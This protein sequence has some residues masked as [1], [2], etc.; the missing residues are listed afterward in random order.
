MTAVKAAMSHADSLMGGKSDKK[1][2]NLSK[3]AFKK[4][5]KAGEYR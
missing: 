5:K 1:S 2:V 3:K 4:D